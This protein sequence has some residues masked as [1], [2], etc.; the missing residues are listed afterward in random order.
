MSI[1]D[2]ATAYRERGVPQIV[3]AGTEYGTGS[4]RDWAAKGPR[5]LG[6]SAVIA[7]SYERIH[8]SNLVGMG[9]APLQFLEGEGAEELGLT[10]REEYEV[11]GLAAGLAADFEPGLEVAVRANGDGGETVFRALVRLGPLRRRPSTTAT[12]ASCTTCCGSSLTT[13]PD[14]RRPAAEPRR[15]VADSRR[16]LP[17][18]RRPAPEQRRAPADPRRTVDPVAALPARERLKVNEIFHSI[19][20]E[21]TFAG[22]PCV[23]VRLTGCQMRCTW[24]DTE[25]SFHEGAW[26]R[27]DEVIEQVLS[28]DCPLAEVT[29][30]NPCSS[31]AFIR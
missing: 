18:P 8:R 6:V 4:S 21:S 29:G 3:L 5:L 1:F 24:C 31:P 30:A 15:A 10:G 25:Y 11:E 22:R 27:V 12:R 19:Q 23:L 7:K 13:T 16:T 20:G 26:M 14:R 17:D 9:I 28:F 2:A